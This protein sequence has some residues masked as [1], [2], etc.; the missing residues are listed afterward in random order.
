MKQTPPTRSKARGAKP[1]AGTPGG[2][3][4]SS[5]ARVLALPAGC[6]LALLL[7]G[8]LVP[9]RPALFWTFVGAAGG[10]L[11]WSAAVYASARRQRRSLT[12][13]ISL[14]RQHW[15]QACAQAAVLLYWGWYVHFVYAF[16]PL[17]VAQLVF[18]YGVDC[19][20][21][22]S[23]RDRYALGFGPFPVILS[24]NL[25]LW[26]RPE[27]FYWQFAMILV[28]FAAKEFIRWNRDG[29]SAHIFNPSSF[30]LAVASILLILAGVSD[31]TLGTAIA[32]T[33]FYPPHMYLVIFLVALPGQL[34]FGVARMTMSAVVTLYLISLIHL[35]ATGTY[36]FFDSH[37]PLPVF[38]GM[39]LLFTDPSTAP[40]SVAGRVIFGALYAIGTATFFVLLTGM[41]V[42][43]FYDKLLPVPLMN[44][45]VRAIDR[46]AAERL[47]ASVPDGTLQATGTP[48]RMH[49]VATSIWVVVFLALSAVRGIGDR[50]RGQA[51]PFWQ[52]ACRAGSARACEYTEAMTLIYCNNGSGWACNEWGLIQVRANRP[53]GN[54]FARACEQ[55]FTPTCEYLR[56]PP[57]SG[58]P[59]QGKP[60]LVGDLPIVLRGTKPPLLER[61]PARLFAIACDQGWPGTCA[62]AS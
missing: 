59:P 35:Q 32:T 42:P 41:G 14:R 6:A 60:P 50:P 56:R 51:L 10:L 38:L 4:N 34:L 22:W 30:P 16:L 13:G 43:N 33:Q 62:P 15:V 8:F 39:H 47:P 25:F 2:P 31:I 27:W 18:A 44:L 17:I 52:Q 57:P 29:R 40:K 9:Q 7:F 5:P 61:D 11:V 20:L 19:L 28:G 36:L 48:W 3:L 23:R 21:T 37:I 26:F 46:F 45:M 54:A 49:A 1:P 58:P 53:P 12:M 55:G 24:I